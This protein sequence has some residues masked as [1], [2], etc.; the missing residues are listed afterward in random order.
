MPKNGD[1]A[2]LARVLDWQSRG[3]GFEPHLLHKK[4]YIDLTTSLNCTILRG[5][6]FL[7]VFKKDIFLRNISQSNQ[8]EVFPYF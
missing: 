5:F 8:K 1:V 2:Q 6:C 4:A 3:R 7:G